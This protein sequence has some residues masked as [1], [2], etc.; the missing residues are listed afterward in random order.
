MAPLAPQAPCSP[1]SPLPAGMTSTCQAQT[2]RHPRTAGDSSSRGSHA[3]SAVPCPRHLNSLRQ[4]LSS[5]FPC[6]SLLFADNIIRLLENTFLS[7]CLPT[8]VGI[9]Y[10]HRNLA[11]MS[12]FS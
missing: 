11:V 8:A 4:L 3:W 9:W 6:S 10:W 7:H 2:P 5:N 1:A 12:L